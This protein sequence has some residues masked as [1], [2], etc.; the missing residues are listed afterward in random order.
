MINYDKYKIIFTVTSITILRLLVDSS[1]ST[2]L[3]LYVSKM[4]YQILNDVIY[5]LLIKN[6][7][8]AK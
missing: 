4:I 3:F 8:L 2:N 1:Y 6:N 7:T 5:Y